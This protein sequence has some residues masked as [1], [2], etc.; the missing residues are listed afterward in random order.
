[1]YR[2]YS[3]DGVTLPDARSDFDASTAQAW[4]GA[5][6]LP[7]GSSAFDSHGSARAPLLAPYML[8]Y[9]STVS[10]SSLSSLET[11]LAAWRAK[12]G[13]RGTL[14]RRL[15]SAATYH[16]ITARLVDVQMNVRPAA[17]H[18]RMVPVRWRWQVL[19]EYWKASSVTSSPFTLNASPKS[20]A[21]VNLGS[22]V[23]R[24]ALAVFSPAVSAFTVIDVAISGVA[25]WTYTGTIAVGDA[26]YVDCGSRR[27]YN[28][29]GTDLYSGFK[30]ESNHASEDWLPLAASA[31]TTVAVTKTGGSTASTA[32][33]DYYIKHV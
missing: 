32:T 21:I 10:A 9:S 3:F 23:I 28:K 7:G 29:A 15:L 18:G 31:T 17:T 6:A 20:C 12:V 1:M 30:L 8:Q 22:A 25:H 33:F 24:D 13:V 4:N 2:L 11:T 27:V 16:D 5:L 26:L 14:R 19:E